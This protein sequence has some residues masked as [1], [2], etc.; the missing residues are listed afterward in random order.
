MEG[1][2]SYMFMKLGV[3]SVHLFACKAPEQ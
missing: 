3:H 2:V 1:S